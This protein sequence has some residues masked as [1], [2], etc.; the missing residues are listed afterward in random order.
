MHPHKRSNSAHEIKVDSS[1]KPNAYTG[2]REISS[3]APFH[4][5]QPSPTPF[6]HK[7]LTI[8]SAP[9]PRW[10]SLRRSPRPLSREGFLAFGNR[11]F[12]PSAVALSPIFSISAPQKLYTDLRLCLDT[13]PHIQISLSHTH[14]HTHTHTHTHTYLHTHTRARSLFR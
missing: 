6:W 2:N 12:A 9:R 8:A 10:G 7:I 11:S 4:H 1:R 14:K 5:R 13:L 3:Q